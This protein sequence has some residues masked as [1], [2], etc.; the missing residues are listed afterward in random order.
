MGEWYEIGVT[1]GIGVAAGVAFAGVLA[2]L[3]FGFASTVLGAVVVGVVAGM[4]INGW[5]G[6]G[7][8]IVGAVIGSVSAASIVRGASRRGATVSGT[9]L[10]LIGAAIVVGLLALIPVVGYVEALL[11]P[12]IAARRARQGP[13]KY[14]GLRSLAK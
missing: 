8:G 6:V 9:A 12:L 11:M 3:R 5:I 4:L 14:A 1:V 10:L 7:G 13:D 2:G